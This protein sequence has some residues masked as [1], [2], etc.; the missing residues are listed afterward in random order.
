MYLPSQYS[1]MNH[2]FMLREICLLRR[3]GFETHVFSGHSSLQRCESN[4]APPRRSLPLSASEKSCRFYGTAQTF[5]QLAHQGEA[6]IRPDA[7]SRGCCSL[8][9]LGVVI[10]AHDYGRAH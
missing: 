7:R 5:V 10:L 1:A 6:A 9:R 4:G 3:C 8:V 2:V